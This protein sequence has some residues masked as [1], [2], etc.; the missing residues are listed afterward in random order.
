MI[1]YIAEKFS[2]IENDFIKATF[3]NKG[4]AIKQV[5]LKKY[6]KSQ[7]SNAPYAINETDKSLI[8][9]LAF[10]A[11]GFN[12]VPVN[13]ENS[14]AL[15]E[16]SANSLTYSYVGGGLK[17][18]RTYSL[19]KSA[20]GLKAPY[21]IICKTSVEN[22]SG[23]VLPLEK[24]YISLGMALPTAGDIY[25]GNLAFTLYDGSGADFAKSTSFVDSSGFLG[26]GASKAKPNLV[27]DT[28]PAVWGAVKNQFFATIFTPKNMVGRGGFAAPLIV[29][30]SAEDKYM[31]NGV[32]GY[33]AFSL[34]TPLTPKQT[35]TLEGN[36]YV[37][38][39]EMDRL[40]AMGGGGHIID[41]LKELNIAPVSISYEYDPCDFLKAQE[42][43]QKRDIP[44]FKKSQEDDL[45]NMQTGIFGYKGHVHFHVTACINEELEQ[46]RNLPKTEIFTRIAQLIDR[47]IHANYR[48]Y[49]GNYIACDEL[50]GNNRYA[51]KYT[52]ADKERFETYLQQKL[53]LIQLPD[54]DEAFL[55]NRILTMYA[56]PVINHRKATEE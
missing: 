47:R 39:K 49:P 42:M 44:E 4:G 19:E 41:R 36:L 29:N 56:N 12:G 1:L 50:E 37:G 18:V 3:T 54:K 16:K 15:T 46:L 32:V 23:K 52:A 35:W 34:D 5:E 11:Q 28:A 33:M 24:I 25:G 45:R 38:P 27:L 14:F 21:T 40:L 20:D 7:G 6:E 31:K 55:R 9:G 22:L 30:E 17:I 43:Q 53:A 2:Y 51:D 26:I 48:L 13:F 8:M 10:P